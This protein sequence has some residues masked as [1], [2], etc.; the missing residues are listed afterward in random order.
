M[1]PYCRGSKHQKNGLAP[2][3]ERKRLCDPPNLPNLISFIC[4][5][6]IN[7]QPLALFLRK[8]PEG[9]SSISVNPKG[10]LGKCLR[11]FKL[12]HESNL[13]G[14]EISGQSSGRH[15]PSTRPMIPIF[16]VPLLEK[17]NHRAEK[18]VV[19]R[20]PHIVPRLRQDGDF[21]PGQPFP[22]KRRIRLLQQRSLASAA[23]NEHRT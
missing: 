19:V 17:G 9:L 12:L 6:P 20:V 1:P 16:P 10:S 3:E 14:R 5:F 18:P 13:D 11:F 15:R 23:E 21:H 4:L 8:E 22:K 7:M 2:L